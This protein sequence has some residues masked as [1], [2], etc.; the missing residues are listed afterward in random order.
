MIHMKSRGRKL[1]DKVSNLELTGD[2]DEDKALAQITQLN[3]T[4]E[5]LPLRIQH[6]QTALAAFDEVI[7]KQCHEFVSKPARPLM[8]LFAIDTEFVGPGCHCGCR[9][10]RQFWRNWK[11]SRRKWNSLPAMCA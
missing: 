3:A 2:L 11:N 8:G 7:V 4:A 1:G 10:A 9:R 6:R 5:F